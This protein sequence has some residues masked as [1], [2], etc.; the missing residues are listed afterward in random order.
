MDVCISAFV[1]KGKLTAGLLSVQRRI[2]V[3]GFSF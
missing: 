3:P 2:N 1:T